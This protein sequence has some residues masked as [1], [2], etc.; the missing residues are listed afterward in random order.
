MK[1]TVIQGR[2]KAAFIKGF[3]KRHAS[4]WADSNVNR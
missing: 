2:I 3:P 4:Y 1:D